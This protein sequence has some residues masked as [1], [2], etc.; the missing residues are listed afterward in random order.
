MDRI[1]SLCMAAGRSKR[2]AS[3]AYKTADVTSYEE[4]KAVIDMAVE[5]HG[6]VDVLY[7]NAGIMP[8]APLIEG[9]RNE[10]RRLPDINVMGVF[11]AYGMEN[12]SALK[13]KELRDF[14]RNLK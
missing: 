1:Y 9:R 6:R 13:L 8:T 3:I 10:W 5:L 2:M 11:T 12:G 7:N 14:G 4:V